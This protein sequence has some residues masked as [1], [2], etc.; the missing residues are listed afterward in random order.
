MQRVLSLRAQWRRNTMGGLQSPQ[1]LSPLFYQRP[2][3][4]GP[5]EGPILPHVRPTDGFP[6]LFDIEVRWQMLQILLDVRIVLVASAAPDHEPMPECH[7]FFTA[8]ICNDTVNDPSAHPLI[9][10]PVA[11]VAPYPVIGFL[12]S[13][14]G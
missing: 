8:M 12:G 13:I 6:V 10:A 9:I 5:F 1:M 2:Q 11:A 4:I 7:P 3:V 14:W